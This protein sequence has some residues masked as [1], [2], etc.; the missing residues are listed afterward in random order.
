LGFLIT[1]ALPAALLPAQPSPLFRSGISLVHLDTEVLDGH[2]RPIT[3]LNKTEFR[4]F[5]EGQEQSVAILSAGEQ[6]LDLILLIDT[7]RSMR[8]KVAE[9]AAASGAALGELHPG[10]R[11]SVLVFNTDCRVVSPLTADLRSTIQAL[12]AVVQLPFRGGTAIRNAV[13]TA[14]D[15]FAQVHDR[16]E[17]C[18]RAVL[19]ITDNF[20]MPGRTETSVV[21]SL[22]EAD[23][24]L[25]GLIVSNR[26]ANLSPFS[27]LGVRK[28]GGIEGIADR[29]G[30]DLIYSDELSTSFP[31]AIRRLRSRYSLYYRLPITQQGRERTVRV[32]LGPEA[33]QRFPGAQVR[34]RKRYS[35]RAAN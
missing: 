23:A 12:D 33:A 22:S 10:D 35:A 11:V 2:G 13:S 29:T 9:I 7:S 28:L 3:G 5:D 26:L 16:K 32:E 34:A 19:V 27:L 25:S 1:V 15:Q 20:G 31:E 24:I 18:R 17:Q 4:I 14:A 6:P 8:V 21:E 30:G